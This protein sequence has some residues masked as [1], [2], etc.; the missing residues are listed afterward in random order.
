MTYAQHVQRQ[1]RAAL[2][3]LH[4][5]IVV[6][7]VI[8][9]A[10]VALEKY[11][12]PG[13]VFKDNADYKLT[14]KFYTCQF[15]LIGLFFLRPNE[16]FCRVDLLLVLVFAY[17]QMLFNF[18]AGVLIITIL[19]DFC[20]MLINMQFIIDATRHLVKHLLELSLLVFGLAAFLSYW[21]GGRAGAT[22]LFVWAVE[23]GIALIIN[24]KSEY[25]RCM[26]TLMRARDR[27]TEEEAWDELVESTGTTLDH[28]QCTFSSEDVVLL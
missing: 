25:R 17:L 26:F 21:F 9:G 1:I 14:H 2:Q 10:S 12:N 18:A 27:V 6:F 24:R 5:T 16:I 11:S 13:C 23:A 20:T 15:F 19:E 7:A 22:V 4:R 3:E 28:L 8:M